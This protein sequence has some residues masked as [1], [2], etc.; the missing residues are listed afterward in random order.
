M[1]W[2]EVSVMKNVLYEQIYHIYSWTHTFFVL[3]YRFFFGVSHITYW[4]GNVMILIMAYFLSV[5]I[6]RTLTQQFKLKLRNS[7]VNIVYG[8]KN[9]LNVN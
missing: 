7:E 2:L 3:N 1:S 5:L 9:Q 8:K 4:H 6:T